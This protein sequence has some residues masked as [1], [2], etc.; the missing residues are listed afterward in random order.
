MHN[1]FCANKLSLNVKKTDFV[2]FSPPS[3]NLNRTVNNIQLCG[4][5]V[6]R[7][8]VT[9]FLGV[10]VDS[11]LTWTNHIYYV[12]MKVSKGV[13]VLNRFRQLLPRTVL[14]S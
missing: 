1:W 14:V 11:H 3:K 9:K 13:G 12:S 4:V 7:S 10:F 8:Y 2:I 6:Q 5:N